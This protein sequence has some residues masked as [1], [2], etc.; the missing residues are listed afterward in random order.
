MGMAGVEVAGVAALIV[1][2]AHKIHERLATGRVDRLSDKD[3]ADVVRIMQ[4]ASA[5]E[6]GA[7]LAGLRQDPG[8]VRNP[9]NLK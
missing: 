2:K 6:V 5:S 7:T 1:A 8:M 3:A 9:R 4:T